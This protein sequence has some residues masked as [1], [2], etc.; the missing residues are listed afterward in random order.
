MKF[1]C[2]MGVAVRV[3]EW[4]RHAG[5]DAVHLSEQGLQRLPNGEIFR[6]ARAER[7]RAHLHKELTDS[8]DAPVGLDFDHHAGAVISVDDAR[9][10]VMSR[11]TG[12]GFHRGSRERDSMKQDRPSCKIAHWVEEAV[13]VVRERPCPPEQGGR[14]EA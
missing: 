4:L 10:R 3:T 7:V 6:K 1:L 12:S 11:S 9:H 14:A 2:D 8:S 13:E 5:H